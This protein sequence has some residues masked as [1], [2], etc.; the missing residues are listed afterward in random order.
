MTRIDALPAV[1]ITGASSG[2]GLACAERLSAGGFRVL[3][4]VRDAAGE[5]RVAER[6]RGRATAV[7]L[8]VTDAASLARAAATAAAC[9][10][11]GGLAGFVGCAGTARWGPLEVLPPALLRR[12]LEVN[13]VGTLAATQAF[14]P[15]LRLGRGRVVWIGSASG[16][17][18]LPYTGAYAAGKAALEGLADALR[19]ELRPW[20][21]PVTLVEAGRIDTPLWRKVAAG[22]TELRHLLSPS[23]AALYAPAFDAAGRGAGRGGGLAPDAVAAAV[24]RALTERRPPARYVVGRD[25]EWQ[26]LLGRLPA[27]L[28]DRALLRRMP[29]GPR[30]SVRG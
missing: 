13:V 21:I 30:G 5:A 1:F 17:C 25:A 18:A 10:G 28:R 11:E 15:L 2:I 24:A 27:V 19:L 9:G 26:L 29:G 22:I 16:R 3:A 7:P 8:E 14:L 4:G 12:E 20:S 23:A 6:T